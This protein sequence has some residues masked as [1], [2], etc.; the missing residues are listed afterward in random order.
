MILRMR[1][2]PVAVSNLIFQPSP[3]IRMCGSLTR[4]FLFQIDPGDYCT[5]SDH[6]SEYICDSKIER[7]ADGCE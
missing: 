5:D 4:P 7:C 6:C 3:I 1:G 2:V